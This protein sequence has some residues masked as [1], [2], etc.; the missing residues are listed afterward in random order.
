KGTESWCWITVSTGAA[1]AG[2]ERL[3]ESSTACNVLHEPGELKLRDRPHPGRATRRRSS[4]VRRQRD[5]APGHCAP[6]VQPRRSKTWSDFSP[7]PLPGWA[8]QIGRASCRERV[9]GSVGRG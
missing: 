9:E 6:A 3:W 1:S 5:R 4:A 7:V 8:P 2:E